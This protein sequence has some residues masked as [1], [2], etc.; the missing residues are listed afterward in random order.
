MKIVLAIALLICGTAS[1]QK[2]ISPLESLFNEVTPK[3]VEWRRYF[4]EYPEL[5]NRE[6]NTSNKVEET[7]QRLG[8]ST[9]KIA[10]TGI[11]AV[12]KGGKPG[13][14]V[15][16]RADM[17][18]L[19]VEERNG[20]S[21]ASKAKGEYNGATVPVMHACGHDSH[22]A[23]LLGAAE[24]LSKIKN[25]IS[26]T[27]VFLFQP[28]EEG[29]PGDE[30]G[31]AALM[32]KEGAMDNPK[33]DAVFGIH[34]NS[35]YDLGK[36]YYKP[37]ATMASSDWFTIKVK[38]KQSH[39]AYPWNSIDPIVVSAEIVQAL[40]TIVSRNIDI[41]QAPV[42]VSVGRI[43]SGVRANIIPEEAM[44]EGTIRTLDGQVQKTVHEKIKLIAQ[45][46]AEANGT[47]AEVMIDTKTLVTYSD[48]V[49][50]AQSLSSLQKAAGGSDNVQL[51]NWV[52]GAED[53]SYFGTKAPS[54]F[55]FLGARDPKY[56][57][58]STA[59]DHHTP[60]FM[61]N[62]TRLDVGVK[63]FVHLV[64]DYAKTTK[65]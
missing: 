50:V 46:I 20:L 54:F 37:G 64:L 51:T 24:V 25:E 17:D 1:A 2:S 63:A 36:I 65:K 52:T 11:V 35:K 56:P 3:V 60:G 28:A 27:V 31:G 47:T 6:F 39:G 48:P 34:I 43:Q 14:V 44:M 13:P 61:I 4:H 59:P 32:I 57:S 29:P 62:D 41:T 5:G 55:F 9:K 22:I 42:V 16:L 23:M 45:K 19:P 15:A 12:L 26:G 18:G 8:I 30:E 7:L 33:V 49:L 53:F 21:F 38:G 40:Q 58:F 10:K